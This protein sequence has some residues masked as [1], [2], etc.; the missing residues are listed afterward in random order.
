MNK[1]QT[2]KLPS[3]ELSIYEDETQIIV[4][5]SL[6]VYCGSFIIGTKDLPIIKQLEIDSKTRHFHI[7]NVIR[8]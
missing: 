2:I 4:T 5:S 1:R 3:N 6:G 7:Q 8:L